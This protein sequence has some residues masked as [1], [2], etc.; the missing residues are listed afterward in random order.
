MVLTLA[1]LF[2][3][4]L[5]WSALANVPGVAINAPPPPPAP[6]VATAGSD[7][8][9]KVVVT[10]RD[11]GSPPLHFVDRVTLYDGNKVLKEWKYDKNSYNKNEL[12]TETAT[13]PVSSDMNLRAVAHCTV[14]GYG[15]A[16]LKVTVL[17]QGTTPADM[18]QRDVDYAGMQVQGYP[19]VSAASSVL[20]SG[21]QQFINGVLQAQ[22]QDN[23]NLQSQLKSYAQSNEGKQFIAKFQPGKPTATPVATKTRMKMRSSPVPSARMAQAGSP[24]FPV[25]VTLGPVSPPPG[26]SFTP[27]YP[28]EFKASPPPGLGNNTTTVTPKATVRPTVRRYMKSYGPTA[29]MYPSASMAPRYAAAVKPTAKATVT[30]KAT[31]KPTMRRYL[32]TYGPTASVYPTASMAPRYAAAVK[33]TGTIG[34]SAKPVVPTVSIK[35]TAVRQTRTSPVASARPTMTR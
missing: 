10:H 31:V 2:L 22:Q 16:D 13:V 1:A 24:R 14:H 11:T 3:G 32:K 27:K 23:K 7:Q 33:P 17:P 29:S 5:S 30:P 34:A 15:V 26:A 6:N 35:P 12:W 8:V 21:D 9:V 28:G 19:Q 18:M 4:L 25:N 20:A